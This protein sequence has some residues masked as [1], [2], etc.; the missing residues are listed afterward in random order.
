L[1]PAHRRTLRVGDVVRNY[2][3]P[4]RWVGVVVEVTHRHAAH[5][6]I[7]V[8]RLLDGRGERVQKCHRERVQR[9]AG[10]LRPCF[11]T[12]EQLAVMRA[13]G[14]GLCVPE[15]YWLRQEPS[16]Q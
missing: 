12:K 3:G 9:D 5:D 7:D 4:R 15:R 2:Y 10:F 8:V 1:S 13:W 16:K 6:L 14:A 11:I